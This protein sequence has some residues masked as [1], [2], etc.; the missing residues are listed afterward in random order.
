MEAASDS[1]SHVLFWIGAWAQ[2]MM[3]YILMLYLHVH[4][5]YWYIWIHGVLRPFSKL[6]FDLG[7]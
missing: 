2:V 6:H 1:E 3:V 7:S 4:I 5:L